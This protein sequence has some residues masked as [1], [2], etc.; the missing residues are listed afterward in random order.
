MLTL[1]D[2]H[3][4]DTTQYEVGTKV[5]TPTGSLEDDDRAAAAGTL[6]SGIQETKGQPPQDENGPLVQETQIELPQIIKKF[7]ISDDLIID[8]Y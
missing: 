5:Q 7:K 3:N 1:Q 4:T 8:N 6:A 2:E